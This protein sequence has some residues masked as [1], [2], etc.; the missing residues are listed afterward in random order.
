MKF[1]TNCGYGNIF[2][3]I[4]SSSSYH[5][6]LIDRFQSE[7]IQNAIQKHWTRSNET[8]RSRVFSI[9]LIRKML[10]GKTKNGIFWG[11][12]KMYLLHLCFTLN[13]LDEEW[14]IQESLMMLQ[15]S[16]MP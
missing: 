2:N 1:D 6:Y 12:S 15:V 9:H 4:R 14:L 13:S 3:N 16:L 7:S 8:N 11:K 10:L 5:D